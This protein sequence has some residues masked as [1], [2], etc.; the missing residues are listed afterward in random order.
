MPWNL[1]KQAELSK[2][3]LDVNAQILALQ[4]GITESQRPALSL[5]DTDI[6]KPQQQLY[7]RGIR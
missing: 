3:N 6:A 2:L 4:N 1:L 5:R 7:E